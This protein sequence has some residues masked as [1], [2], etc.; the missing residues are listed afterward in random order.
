MSF[1]KEADERARQKALD[2][3]AE[4]VIRVAQLA[5]I[6]EDC[7]VSTAEEI[8]SLLDNGT[9]DKIGVSKGDVAKMVFQSDWIFQRTHI[10]VS[11][12]TE[13]QREMVGNICLAKA[14]VHRLGWD[15]TVVKKVAMAQILP[16]LN[17]FERSR[18]DMVEEMGA[19]A[20]LML[21]EIDP[22]EEG[23]FRN[24]TKDLMDSVLLDRRTKTCP[25]IF[26]LSNTKVDLYVGKT[27]LLGK[28]LASTFD[29]FGT[30]NPNV[31]WL[32]L[33]TEEKKDGNRT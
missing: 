11:G 4:R 1:F 31:I 25:T 18:F 8:E 10:M 3:E 24:E 27:K 22:P 28:V 12:G 19:C 32:N 21:T 9:Y 29:S 5:G 30:R 6:P 20:T 2:L 15:G 17:S 14:I 33:I 26:T 7:L 23:S 13:Q 16:L